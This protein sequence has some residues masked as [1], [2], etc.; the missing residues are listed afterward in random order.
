M[1]KEVCMTRTISNPRSAVGSPPA[2]YTGH[3]TYLYAFDVAYEL[4]P[5]ARELTTML[6]H[7]I[8]QFQIDSNKR[9]PRQ[10][11]FYRPQMVRLPP[12][13]RIGPAGTI[14]IEREAKI[15]S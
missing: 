7:P 13:E 12:L 8:A 3:V 1:S 11:M 5:S 9:A 2:R 4:A 15:F 6:G 14:R 10:L